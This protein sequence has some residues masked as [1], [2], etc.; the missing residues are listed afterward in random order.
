[1]N[2]TVR[3]VVT[4]CLYPDFPCDVQAPLLTRAFKASAEPSLRQGFAAI[5]P[6][7]IGASS[8]RAP[9]RSRNSSIASRAPCQKA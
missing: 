4:H 6:D 9:R 8:S 7:A 3:F 5:L 2:S 1:M